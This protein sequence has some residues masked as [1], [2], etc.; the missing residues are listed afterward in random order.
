VFPALLD[1]DKEEMDP[2]LSC[3]PGQFHKHAMPRFLQ[4]REA[5]NLRTVL[6][7]SDKLS[8]DGSSSRKEKL[9]LV[10]E[11]LE[12]EAKARRKMLDCGWGTDAWDANRWITG[13][14]HVFPLSGCIYASRLRANES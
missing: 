10:F 2:V 11:D 3:F 1:E 5:E 6:A 13:A 14:P 8:K 7:E 9:L 4:L 12:N